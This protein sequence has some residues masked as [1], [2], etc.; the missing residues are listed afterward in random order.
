[1]S[2][3]HF[4]K[5]FKSD[6]LGQ[7]DLEDFNEEGSRLIFTISHVNQENDVAVAGRKGNFNIA[8]FKEKIKPLVLNATNSKVM[9][10]LCGGSPFVEDWQNVLV[11]LYIDPSVKMKGEMV[12][13]VRIRTKTPVVTKPVLTP[14]EP[15]MWQSALDAY[16]RDGS[17]E[18]VLSRRSISDAHQKLIK[19]TCDAE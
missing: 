17:L 12:G 18:K 10:G 7:A 14:D 1:M 16:K 9:K 19:D 6:H 4:R 8:Y 15:A 13:G 5:V 3:T 11:Q 2:K